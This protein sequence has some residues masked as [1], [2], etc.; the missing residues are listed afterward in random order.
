M[1][2]IEILSNLVLEVKLLEGTWNG[3]SSMLA[4]LSFYKT[5]NVKLNFP[6]CK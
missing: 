2:P 6:I 5:W 3:T 4:L 1:V